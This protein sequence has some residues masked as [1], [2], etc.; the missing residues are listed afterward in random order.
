MA[1]VAA[2]GWP[3]LGT[4]A[5]LWRAG[6]LADPFPNWSEERFALYALYPSRRY[7]PAN[8]HAFIDFCVENLPAG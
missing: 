3:A 4:G 7:L 8:V 5:Q 2:L 6:Q 1:D